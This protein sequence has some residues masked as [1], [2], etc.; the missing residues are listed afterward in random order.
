MNGTDLAARLEPLMKLAAARD[1]GS[2]IR[3]YEGL[4]FLRAFPPDRRTLRQAETL[5]AGIPDRVRRLRESGA[6]MSAFEEPE[7]S[8]IAG[9]AF[10]AIFHYEVVRRLA[11]LE[12]GRVAID[13]DCYEL[14]DRLAGPWRRLFPLVEEDTM[15][16]PH[17]PY[18]EW[19]SRAAGGLDRSLE[20]LLTRIESLDVSAKEKADLYDS[21]QLP[22]R[23]ELESTP[24]SRTVAGLRPRRVFY[25]KGSL[26]RRSEVVLEQELQAEPLEVEPLGE[27][28]G[29]AFLNMAVAASAARY[30]ELHGFTY[31]DPRS[32][33]RAQAGRGVELYFCGVP[34]EWRLPL[35]AYH[36]AMIFKNGVPAGYFETLSLFDRMEVG[37]NLYYTFR[38]GETAWIFA[39]V[40]RLFSQLLGVASFSIDPYQIGLENE[41]AIASGAFWFYRKLGFR[42]VLPEL[43]RVVAREE[44]RLMRKPGYRSP[45]ATLRRLAVAPL[46]FDTP[47]AAEGDWDRFSVR[48]V[49][50]AAQRSRPEEAAARVATAL[51]VKVGPHPEFLNFA[52]VLDQIPGLADW[53]E[54]DKRLA[55]A[56]IRAKMGPGET[57]YLR[58]MQ[59]HARLRS[60]FIRLGSG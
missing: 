38:E 43:V 52:M 54:A 23:W 3:L 13:W 60:E 44:C 11:E 33:L 24:A 34:A 27:E 2:L 26:I 12:T 6:D 32:V 4:L 16:E 31:G 17:I 10:T 55:M 53:P 46:V 30:R 15:V 40:L 35:R 21:L 5:L 48:H 59:K 28:G 56:V 25:H 19:L 29:Q 47:G 7:V 1:A 41:E 9:T 39:R 14:T 8:G 37:F 51:G 49:A 36:A 42:P 57:L 22:V 58:L 45:A 20:F 18:L 50:L